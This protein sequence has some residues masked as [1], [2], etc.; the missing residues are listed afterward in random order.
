MIVTHTPFGGNDVQAKGLSWSTLIRSAEQ[1]E[2][3]P[4]SPYGVALRAYGK[5]S[6]EV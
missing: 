3:F 1:G 2:N 5:C 4:E 6:P